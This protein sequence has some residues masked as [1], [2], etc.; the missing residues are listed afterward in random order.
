MG[1]LSFGSPVSFLLVERV[2][3][4]PGRSCFGSASP[5]E[6]PLGK[7]V[8]VIVQGHKNLCKR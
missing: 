7:G 6:I 1:S 5:G 8:L 2:S 3:G 4:T